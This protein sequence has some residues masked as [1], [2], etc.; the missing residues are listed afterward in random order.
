MISEHARLEAFLRDIERRAP[1]VFLPLMRLSSNPIDR[2]A[3]DHMQDLL[4]RTCA[5]LHLKE[6]T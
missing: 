6:P 1:I 4:A 5:W 3:V 2:S